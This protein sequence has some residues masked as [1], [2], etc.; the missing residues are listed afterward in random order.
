M[1]GRRR[2]AGHHVAG[3]RAGRRLKGL[4]RKRIGAGTVARVGPEDLA[5]AAVFP[6]VLQPGNEAR[7]RVRVRRC[8]AQPQIVAHVA[9][10]EYVCGSTADRLGGIVGARDRTVAGHRLQK[11]VDVEG[12]LAG[13]CPGAIYEAVDFVSLIDGSRRGLSCGH[14]HGQRHGEEGCAERYRGGH[15]KDA[16]S[17]CQPHD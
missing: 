8:V 17:S 3:G 1:A 15:S 10:G 9:G 13:G 4:V 14:L 5:D 6:S 7:A 12:A 2:P 16:R 11:D